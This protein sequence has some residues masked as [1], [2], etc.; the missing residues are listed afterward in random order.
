LERALSNRARC[1]RERTQAERCWF[2][3][4]LFIWK[5]E[6]LFHPQSKLHLSHFPSDE[7]DP[8]RLPAESSLPF[9]ELVGWE[10]VRNEAFNHVHRLSRGHR[11]RWS[12]FQESARIF[13]VSRFAADC[14]GLNKCGVSLALSK[15]FENFLQILFHS[16]SKLRREKDIP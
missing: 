10:G 3:T 16:L 12:T 14:R 2:Q 4:G 5:A 13:H 7:T 11:L 15:D 1:A 6:Q 9:L 8:P